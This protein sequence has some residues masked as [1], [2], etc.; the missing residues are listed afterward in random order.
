LTGVI[1]FLVDTIVILLVQGQSASLHSMHEVLNGKKVES[2][3]YGHLTF[4]FLFFRN[5]HFT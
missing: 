4:P 2:S 1:R 3:W 5:L